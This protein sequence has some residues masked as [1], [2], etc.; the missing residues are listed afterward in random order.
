MNERGPWGV[1]HTPE[2]SEPG[3]FGDVWMLT[4]NGEVVEHT[5]VYGY[6]FAMACVDDLNRQETA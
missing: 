1:L 6:G 3:E 4:L 5:A 2:L